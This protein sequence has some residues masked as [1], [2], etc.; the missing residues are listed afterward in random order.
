MQIRA[1][2]WNYYSEQEINAP[3]VEFILLAVYYSAF[4]KAAGRQQE[5]P[6]KPFPYS[7]LQSFSG[8][9]PGKAGNGSASGFV[10]NAV[11][12]DQLSW[13]D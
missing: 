9:V 10:N 4:H 2:T 1:W 12:S 11:T 6:Q 3:F 5:W 8:I 7:Q 13:L